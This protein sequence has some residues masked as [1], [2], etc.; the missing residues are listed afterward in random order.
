MA[1]APQTSCSFLTGHI[2][3]EQYEQESCFPDSDGHWSENDAF[4]SENFWRSI[5]WSN[6][7]S[8][9]PSIDT[10][11]QQ[12]EPGSHNGL[13]DNVGLASSVPVHSAINFQ[14]PNVFQTYHPQD[15]S[16]I[17]RLRTPSIDFP[18]YPANGHSKLHCLI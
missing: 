14:D 4:S 10:Y 1:M 12:D 6:D 5:A 16:Q 15:G 9:A 7:Q 11:K 17:T 8:G 13:S 18:A 3:G 2:T